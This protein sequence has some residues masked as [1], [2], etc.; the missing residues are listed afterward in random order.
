MEKD[1]VNELLDFIERHAK[2][3]CICVNETVRLIPIE[4][5][6]LSE[7]T[8]NALKNSGFRYLDEIMFYSLDQLERLIGR[9]EAEEADRVHY[10]L[11][12]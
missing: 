12:K 11:S 2:Q 7:R 10:R 4:K 3:Q 8:Y 1:V 9:E 6:G 5:A